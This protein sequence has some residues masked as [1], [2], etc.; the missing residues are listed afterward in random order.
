MSLNHV[1][2]SRRRSHLAR[3]A[4]ERVALATLKHSC[5]NLSDEVDSRGQVEDLL[6]EH[7]YMLTDACFAC[8]VS[9]SCFTS[10]WMP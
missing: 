1:A 8:C 5:R 9:P 6:S 7:T 4:E 10:S 2:L 3:Q